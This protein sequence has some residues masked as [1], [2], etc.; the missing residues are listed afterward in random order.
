MFYSGTKSVTQNIRRFCERLLRAT[1]TVPGSRMRPSEPRLS[2]TGLHELHR[3][4]QPSRR[5]CHSRELKDQPCSFCRRFGTPN[6]IS[7]ESSACTR[8]VFCC[9]RPSGNENQCYKY[10]GTTLCLSTDP[11][12]CMLQVSGTTLQQVETFKYLGLVFTCDIRRSPRGL[13]HGL[14]KLTQFCVTFIALWSYNG[15]FKTP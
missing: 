4:S 12:Q 8:L 13:M 7:T 3:Q 10:R 2:T 5:G 6:I 11:S 1:Q 9:V 14:V 15:S